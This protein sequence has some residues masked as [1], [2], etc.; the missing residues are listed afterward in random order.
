MAANIMLPK[1]TS[2]LSGVTTLGA[3]NLE[4]NGWLVYPVVLR[5]PVIILPQDAGLN[6]YSGK[7]IDLTFG[8]FCSRGRSILNGWKNYLIAGAFSVSD[9]EQSINSLRSWFNNMTS[10]VSQAQNYQDS[11]VDLFQERGWLQFQDA[12]RSATDALDKDL[13]AK[14]EKA[15]TTY[16]KEMNITPHDPQKASDAAYLLARPYYQDL[17]KAYQDLI[18]MADDTNALNIWKAQKYAKGDDDYSYALW[19]KV[20]IGN[21]WKAVSMYRQQLHDLYDK[22]AA[23]IMAIRASRAAAE[24]TSYSKQAITTKMTTG[25]WSWDEQQ[26]LQ[27]TN[28][29]IQ[30]AAK[31]I[32]EFTARMEKAF[33]ASSLKEA[34]RLRDAIDAEAKRYMNFTVAKAVRKQPLYVLAVS[35][36]NAA[37]NRVNA[38]LGE[39]VTTNWGMVASLAIAGIGGYILLN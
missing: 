25:L 19:S 22:A 2:V 26:Q 21:Q 6:Q 5:L 28:A 4:W 39:D 17:I 8:Q 27:M 33:Q 20:L 32:D 24:G 35:R 23:R 30:L 18:G 10:I 11:G 1:I 15:R 9:Y 12:Y 3:T 16:A 29:Q 14:I 34:R 31:R 13:A 38:K 7:Y 36:Y 37:L